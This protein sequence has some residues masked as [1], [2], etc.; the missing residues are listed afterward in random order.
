MIGQYRSILC[1]DMSEQSRNMSEFN[2][3][4]EETDFLVLKDDMVELE[5]LSSSSD[6]SSEFIFVKDEEE[7]VSWWW[8][9]YILK[10]IINSC[11]KHLLSYQK[12]FAICIK[13]H[14]YNFI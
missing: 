6:E 11:L 2:S 8:F 10:K 3:S 14:V 5:S 1:S 13:F 4:D 12:P 7:K 9:L